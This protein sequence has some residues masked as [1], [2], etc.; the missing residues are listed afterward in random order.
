MKK[1]FIVSMLI[2]SAWT[3]SQDL[4]ISN[5]S[6]RPITFTAYAYVSGTGT[7]STQ[8]HA[9]KTVPVNTI[10]AFFGFSGT[11]WLDAS[12]AVASPQ[13]SG[14]AVWIGVDIHYTWGVPPNNVINDKLLSGACGAAKLTS[15]SAG[16]MVGSW[17]DVG[18]GEVFVSLDN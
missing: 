16:S 9:S 18:S 6:N 7:C 14:T 5:T 2:T 10:D 4:G 12:N 13:P 17:T 11:T 3:F 15:S 8:Y 1:L